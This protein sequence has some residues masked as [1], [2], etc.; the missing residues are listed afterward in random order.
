[1]KKLGERQY[2]VGTIYTVGSLSFKLKPTIGE[3]KSNGK[4]DLGAIL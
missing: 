1:M 2:A 3:M 4:L